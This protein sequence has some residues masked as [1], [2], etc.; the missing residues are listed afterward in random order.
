MFHESASRVCRD[1][2]F[3]YTFACN[4]IKKIVIINYNEHHVSKVRYNVI[5]R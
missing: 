1:E 4:M 2:E 5:L 3:L